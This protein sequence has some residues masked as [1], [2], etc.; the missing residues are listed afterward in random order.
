MMK[1]KSNLILNVIFIFICLFNNIA[2]AKDYIEPVFYIH[3]VEYYTPHFNNTAKIS[4]QKETI[5]STSSIISKISKNFNMSDEVEKDFEK[6]FSAKQSNEET[7]P[8]GTYI[9]IMNS[10]N[11]KFASTN[12]SICTLEP[13]KI[14]FSKPGKI[15]FVIYAFFDKN[16]VAKYSANFNIINNAS[17]EKLKFTPVPLEQL[18][19]YSLLHQYLTDE[20]LKAAY[21]AAIPFAKEVYGLKLEEQLKLLTLILRQYY[22]EKVTYST[23]APHFLDAYG[24]LITK[25]A[26][27]QGSTC[28]TGLILNILGIDYEHIN[29]NLWEHQWCRV[30]VN[31]EYWIVDAYGLY[32]GPNIEPYDADYP[33]IIR[34]EGKLIYADEETTALIRKIHRELYSE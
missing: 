7:F 12:T 25:Q 32:C 14:I 27:C 18:Q 3:E 4:T 6:I 5:H 15:S 16:K 22:E 28:A 31:G 26:S 23:E 30:Y 29:H 17:L 20:Q 24:F 13:N 8:V 19:N 1:R 11:I 33:N 10:Q 9:E 34:S 2:F 21:N